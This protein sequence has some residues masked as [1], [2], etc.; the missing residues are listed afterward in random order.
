MEKAFK[1]GVKIFVSIF[2]FSTFAFSF[3]GVEAKEQIKTSSLA[4]EFGPTEV[5]D[6]T[7]DGG[8]NL[9]KEEVLS[10]YHPSAEEVEAKTYTTK[11]S[12]G[13]ESEDDY[14]LAVFDINTLPKDAVIKTIK[15]VHIFWKDSENTA[16]LIQSSYSLDKAYNGSWHTDWQLLAPIDISAEAE[17]V[18]ISQELDLST[19]ITSLSDLKS[20]AVKIQINSENLDKEV[21][22]KSVHDYLVLK[23]TYNRLPKVD[24]VQPKDK[25]GFGAY[26][27]DEEGYPATRPVFRWQVSDPDG[28]Q[29]ISRWQI[30]KKIGSTCD[31]SNPLSE[32]L[33]IA[34]TEYQPQNDL[35]E[36]SYCWR[37]GVS[38]DG[39]SSYQWSN[40]YEFLIDITAPPA[41]SEVRMDPYPSERFTNV[42]NPHIWGKFS[43][44]DND[45]LVA[46]VSFVNTALDEAYFYLIP[47]RKNSFDSTDP[48]ALLLYV[49]NL[50]SSDLSQLSFSRINRTDLKQVKSLKDGVYKV[51]AFAL[52]QVAN[53]SQSDDWIVF[54]ELYR[55][56]TK[57]PSAPLISVELQ[58]SKVVISWQAVEDGVYYG[59][60]RDGKLVAYTNSLMFVEENLPQGTEYTYW[61]I[62]IDQAGNQ[63]QA[64]NFVN[65][66][67]P[68][69]RVSSISYQ[70]AM[71]YAPS[72]VIPEA[73]AKS[74]N[75]T[76]DSTKEES[77]E[78]NQGEVQAEEISEG[79]NWALVVAVI[80][81]V[82]LILGGG[83]YWWYVREEDEI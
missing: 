43:I 50:R 15:L 45:S 53:S 38:D 34:Q 4:Q 3:Q 62:A 22:A 2:L 21:V 26:T 71:S 13:S 55:L 31:F 72:V 70:P 35:S 83:L 75:K 11:D 52:D 54:D 82:I 64:S 61:V 33:L 25:T 10:L 23:I 80:L 65:I 81:G 8:Y 79:I 44:D 5:T 6:L 78:E 7:D 27:Q 32:K 42:N 77:S 29:L 57:A 47:R 24:L 16:N 39:G 37:V 48:D 9:S 69:P 51:V 68:K 56:D 28:D 59:V 17:E 63:S 66:Y 19:V 49:R 73:Q 41:L 20:L 30:T 18:E 60:Y 40:T 46:V 76:Q 12:W 74:Q 14:L 36:G 1:L 58:D 67:I